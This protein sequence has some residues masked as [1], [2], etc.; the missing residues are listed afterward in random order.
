M[1][2]V[3]ASEQNKK[4]K[5][6]DHPPSRSVTQFVGRTET[7][8]SRSQCQPSAQP[9][10]RRSALVTQALSPKEVGNITCRLVMSRAG[11]T[12][13]HAGVLFASSKWSLT[14]PLSLIHKPWGE[15]KP[16]HRLRSHLHLG[17]A[18]R[19][20]PRSPCGEERETSLRSSKTGCPGG[21]GALVHRGK[22]SFA[23]YPADLHL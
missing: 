23:L 4:Q 16:G 14:S 18:N 3:V 15:L 8:L 22:C 2:G 10:V 20:A 7:L 11:F 21:G 17:R 5:K 6:K 12:S 9:A 19:S 1:G 13:K